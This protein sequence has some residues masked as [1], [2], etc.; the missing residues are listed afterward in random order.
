MKS[1][2]VYFLIIRSFGLTILNNVLRTIAFSYPKGSSVFNSETI[3]RGLL[4]L[5][6]IK[7]FE[8]PDLEII[9][10]RVIGLTLKS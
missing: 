10:G 3:A 7:E 9:K 4:A 1:T 8:P 6:I 5:E 2:C